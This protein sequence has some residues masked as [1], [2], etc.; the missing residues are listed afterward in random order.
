MYLGSSRH[1]SSAWNFPPD[2]S[3]AHGFMLVNLATA[4]SLRSEYDKAWG[5]LQQALSLLGVKHVL[6]HAVLLAVYVNLL[7]GGDGISAAIKVKPGLCHWV[8]CLH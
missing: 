6:P 1:V 7:N 5:L 4:H 3:C 2:L 8:F